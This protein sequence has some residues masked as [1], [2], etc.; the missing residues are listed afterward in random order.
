MMRRLSVQPLTVAMPAQN[1]EMSTAQR[2][3]IAVQLDD[4][5]LVRESPF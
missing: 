4:E 3:A 1:A 5:I 2:R